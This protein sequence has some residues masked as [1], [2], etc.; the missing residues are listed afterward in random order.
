MASSRGQQTQAGRD[1]DATRQ[2]S[3]MEEPCSAQISFQEQQLQ[4][5]KVQIQFRY[6]EESLISHG[7]VSRNGRKDRPEPCVKILPRVAVRL[8]CL[9][10]ETGARQ[11]FAAPSASASQSVPQQPRISLLL[12]SPSLSCTE[13]RPGHQASRDC[14]PGRERCLGGQ[15]ST[16]RQPLR[17]LAS[18]PQGD[19]GGV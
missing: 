10:R 9:L 15:A 1:E 13:G 8:E 11:P 17:L 3:R 14:G 2:L 18:T 6:R 12:R 5:T 16:Q 7:L 19:F 4:L